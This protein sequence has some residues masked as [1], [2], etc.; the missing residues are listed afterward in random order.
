M[1]IDVLMLAPHRATP[2]GAVSIADSASVRTTGPSGTVLFEAIEVTS[3]VQW[4]AAKVEGTF[5]E[6]LE[7][8]RVRLIDADGVYWYFD[9]SLNIVQVTAADWTTQYSLP[10][11]LN[12]LDLWTRRYLRI[13]VHLVRSDADRDPRIFGVYVLAE[14]PTWEGPAA[15][16][17]RKITEAVDALRPVF[18]FKHVVGTQPIQ[19]MSLKSERSYE[20]TELSAVVVDDDH[21]SAAYADR[22]VTFVGPPVQPGSE[23][24]V[25]AKCRVP[26]SIKR[27]PESRLSPK[28]PYWWIQDTTRH[29]GLNGVMGP[30]VIGTYEVK[31]VMSQLRTT[32]NGIADRLA[33][34]LALRTAMQTGFARAIEIEFPSGRTVGAQPDGL[35][36]VLEERSGPVLPMA[37][38]VL[39]TVLTEYVS[40]VQL[41]PSRVGSMPLN[42]T[43]TINLPDSTSTVSSDTIDCEE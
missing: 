15:T 11:H 20:I 33:D 12:N 21:K 5:D 19:T 25:A 1:A 16:V 3:Y 10:S 31:R 30:L 17:A 28:V 2:S 7:S 40:A 18:I 43:I 42:T 23:I 36:E 26:S 4:M 13:A 32:V 37:T 6:T 9:D 27:A 14:F 22:T 39:T 8:V 41:R 38:A 35:I 29:S 34:A 24:A